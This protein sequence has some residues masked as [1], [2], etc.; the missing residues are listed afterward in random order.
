[1][2][3]KDEFEARY[4]AAARIRWSNPDS[5][6]TTQDD[7][8]VAQAVT[9]AEA[10]F[11]TEVQA[12]YDNDDTRHKSLGSQAV[13]AFLLSYGA[14]GAKTAE[15]AFKRLERSAELLR[16]TT[17]RKHEVPRSTS[18]LTVTQDESGDTPAFDS[19]KMEQIVGSTTSPR[20]DDTG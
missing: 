6:G 13:R 11:Q 2:A 1:M 17:V 15:D 14:A 12:D 18:G 4:S 20:D 19:K 5:K 16:E 9:D 10:W 8:L 3:L 7:T